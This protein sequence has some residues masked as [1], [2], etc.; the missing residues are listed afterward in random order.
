[1]NFRISNLLLLFFSFSTCFAQKQVMHL[2]NVTY[3][4]FIKDR[5]AFSLSNSAT[6]D[7]ALVIP[8][9]RTLTAHLFDKDFKKVDE[10]T[11]ES[12]RI[13]FKEIIGYRVS[14]KHYTTLFSTDNKRYFGV[15]D[16]DFE[17]GKTTTEQLDLDMGGEEVLEAV[18]HNNR[19][20]LLSLDSNFA[21]LIIR[22]LL[23]NR[24][25]DRKELKIDSPASFKD[26]LTRRN[27]ADDLGKRKGSIFNEALPPEIVEI[28]NN[29]PNS[30]ETTSKLN[31]LYAE[32]EILILTFDN[33]EAFT[34]AY[35]IDLNNFAVKEKRFQKEQIDNQPLEK[36]NSFLYENYLFQLGVN[37]DRMVFT[38]TDFSTGKN[39]K[40]YRA[41][42]D[43]V[44]N[45]KNS[46]LLQ[47]NGM[48]MA[49]DGVRPLD[50]TSQYLRK[51]TNG[52]PGIAIQKINGVYQT[53]IGGTQPMGSGGGGAMMMVGGGLAGGA[54]G[55]MIVSTTFNP[56]YMSYGSY[57]NTKSIYIESLFDAE[58]NHIEGKAREN[59]FD[60]VKTYQDSFK[61]IDAEE[62]F[63][64]NEKV[65]FGYYNKK[66][67]VY[68]IVEFEN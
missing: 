10:I 56:T 27:K 65:Y 58:F 15:V 14:N 42:K 40:T 52:Q 60:K 7:L 23:E 55:A 33:F 54:I 46:L 62:V 12:L 30:L 20:F 19:F 2:E 61:K 36:S 9:K 43:R 59:V 37:N 32:G 38:V 1:M 45:F 66:S 4:N 39:L 17:T 31:K 64:H 67:E 34:V 51:I 47:K 21:G 53:T 11:A 24:T 13:K 28:D 49:N 26:L 35:F 44:I 8:D 3:S 18:T 48:F 16:F 5:T 57:A 22:E 25:F 68:N 29:N 63:S 6:G 41:T 50:D